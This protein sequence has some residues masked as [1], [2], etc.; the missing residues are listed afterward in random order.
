MQKADCGIGSYEGPNEL[1]TVKT[2]DGVRLQAIAL[3]RGTTR[4]EKAVV[5]CHGA[6]RNKNTLPIVQTAQILATKY[7][8]FT[9]DFRGHMESK[10]VFHADGD[11]E[12]DLKAMIDYLK[13]VGYKKIAVIGW[14]IG[15]WTALLSAARGRAI[16]AVIAGAPPPANMASQFYIR[17]LAQLRLLPD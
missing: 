16:D 12:L 10:G 15:A 14:S 17:W 5:V 13:Q 11:T 3:V 1:F 8:V 7:D 4:N 9:F 2:D 6:G